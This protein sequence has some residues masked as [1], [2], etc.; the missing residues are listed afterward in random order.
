[1]AGKKEKPQVQIEKVT[2]G[3]VWDDKACKELPDLL[4]GAIESALG[5]DVE[6][7]RSKP[8]T[9]FIVAT[10]VEEAAFDKEK[11]LLSLWLKAL[12][13]SGE[14]SL[15][16]SLLQKGSLKGVDDKSLPAKLKKV[17][18]A[19]GGALGKN[20]AKEIADAAKE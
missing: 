3:K 19:V 1:M 10:S 14:K 16:S 4:S 9:G 8:K 11:G 7:V 15:K 18:D 12:L 5:S 17:A 20:L 6:V 2:L 13:T